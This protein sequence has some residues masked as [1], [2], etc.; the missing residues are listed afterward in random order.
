MPRILLVED[1]PSL[2]A[3]V[4]DDLLME[5]YAVDVVTDGERLDAR[6][7][8]SVR[9]VI[10]L[11]VMLPRKG[12][13]YRLPGIARSRCSHPGHHADRAR[14]RRPTRSSDSSSAPMTTSPNR[15]ADV[16]SN[17]RESRT[18]SK[19]DGCK[20]R[21]QPVRIRKHSIS[22]SADANQEEGRRIEI[23]APRTQDA[24]HAARAAG[25]C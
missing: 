19:R 9:S 24:S 25:K 5:G 18:S 3:G 11:D 8:G 16:S 6:L 10:L 13:F 21:S 12:R 14:A 7:T 22:T 1:E 23:T 17:P 20:P 15:S 2:A 4:R